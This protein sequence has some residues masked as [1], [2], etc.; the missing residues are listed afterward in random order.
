MLDIKSSEY[1][2]ENNLLR[3]AHSKSEEQLNRIQDKNSKDTVRLEEEISRLKLTEKRFLAAEQTLR[4]LYEE[5]SK[6]EMLWK[7][8]GS[9]PSPNG[10]KK[11]H[12]QL[13]SLST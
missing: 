13:Y 10:L 12:Y 5:L 3:L 2:A 9:Y 8:M 1:Q 11:V 6:S 7:E 4:N